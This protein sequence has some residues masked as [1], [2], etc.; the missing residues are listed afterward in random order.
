[1]ASMHPEE[2]CMLRSHLG[3]L[4][5]IFYSLHLVSN[6]STTFMSSGQLEYGVVC[7]VVR[8]RLRRVV[9]SDAINIAS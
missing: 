7:S 9:R 2:M 1:M 8:L 6:S 4:R 3:F 5:T